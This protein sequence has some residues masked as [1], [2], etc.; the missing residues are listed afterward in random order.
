[1]SMTVQRRKETRFPS[2]IM[3]KVADVRGGVS[4]QTK[5][6]GGKYLLEGTVLSAPIDG[7]CHVVKVAKINEDV[8][9]SGVAIKVEKGHH[10]VVGDIL[11][12]KLGNK[13]TTITAI[14]AS[15]KSV[16]TLTIKAALGELKKGAFVFLAEKESADTKSALKYAPFAING[17]TKPVVAGDNL[18]TDAWL[19]AVTKGNDLPTEIEQALKGVINY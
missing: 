5:E 19:I 17:T 12:A 6:L 8:A 13:A 9:A 15:D 10:F 4:V 14:D 1:M 16:D 2:V 7:I 3:H 11:C 18:D